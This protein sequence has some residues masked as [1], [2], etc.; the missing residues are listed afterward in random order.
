ME[1]LLALTIIF[2]VY[3][4]GD[5]IAVK[6]KAI[7][8]MLCTASLIFMVAFWLGLPPTIFADS[9][10]LGI[11]G[12]LITLLLTHMGTTM[13]IKQLAQQ[14]KVVVIGVLAVL[15]I[16]FAG[17]FLA[18]PMIGREYA[19]TGSPVLA[20]GVVASL[21]MGEAATN[22]GL[23]DLAVYA[24]L[25]L[26]IQGFIG[27]PMGS[28]CVK[29]EAKRLLKLHRAGTETLQVDVVDVEK[30]KKRWIRIP[31]KYNSGNVMIAKLA[32][33]ALISTQ[34][35]NLTGGRVN[36]LVF[37]LILG[38]IFKEIGFLDD[39]A[40][41]KANA[42]GMVIACTTVAI[43]GSLADATPEL[44]LQQILPIVVLLIVGIGG[45]ILVCMVVGKLMGFSSQLSIG[46]GFT[47]LFGFPGTY[48]I[49]QEV[50]ESLAENEEEK[51]LIINSI[52]PKMVVAGIV[53]IS[54]SSVLVAGV[55]AGMI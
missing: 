3:A 18:G 43:F 35:A 32:V 23:T 51:Q 24:V 10:M 17:I 15:A 1:T 53:T 29:A 40:L 21:I 47:A 48:L 20:G 50:A 14:W 5:V 45:M 42:F 46:I 28:I 27:F 22:K 4:I 33:V 31:E 7:I 41:N 38:V 55:V 26:V 8:T 19:M 37:C 12:V 36:K 16:T 11:G 13:S 6:T 49:P 25:V 54:I 39:N 34:L 2:L 44:L 52:Q 30:K 9:Q